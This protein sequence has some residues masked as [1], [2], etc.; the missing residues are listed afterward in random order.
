MI[1]STG[2]LKVNEKEELYQKIIEYSFEPTIIH[3]DQKVL[4]INQSGADFLKAVQEDVIGAS[5]LGIFKP[6]EKDAIIERISKVLKTGEPADRIEQTLVKSDGSFVDVELTC[7]PVEYGDRSAIQSVVRDITEHKSTASQLS[8]IR[9]EIN[10]LATAVVPVSEGVSI[11]PLAG[12]VDMDR[13][14]QLL[15]TIPL[16][17][18]HL[19]LD[20]LIIDFSGIYKLDEVVV[21]FLFNINDI[22]KL[23]GIHPIFTGIRPELARKAVEIGKDLSKMHTIGTV[24]QAIK[25][26][27]K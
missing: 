26:I 12:R 1:D 9:H 22:V 27:N 18:Q 6:D 20:Y 4:Y 14:N 15:D 13:V 11:I 23:L 5:A 2:S 21:G 3:A 17:L 24:K 10:E 25:H 19:E 16:K 7:T 8:E